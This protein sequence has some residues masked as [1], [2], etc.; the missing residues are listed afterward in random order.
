[1]LNQVGKV[2]LGAH[3]Q[4]VEDAVTITNFIHLLLTYG[5]WQRVSINVVNI[6]QQM[7]GS[8]FPIL[9]QYMELHA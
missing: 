1:M 9:L 3:Q 2:S 7:T 8:V 4:F 5:A 6:V